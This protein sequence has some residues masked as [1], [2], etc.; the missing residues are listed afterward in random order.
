MRKIKILSWILAAT[1][2]MNACKKSSTET[3]NPT[4]QPVGADP[5]TATLQGNVVDENSQ[6]AIGVTIKVGTKTVT[7]D[8]KGFFRVTGAALDKNASLVT[9]EKT[10]YFKAYRSFCATSGA[11]QVSIKL[12]K[13]NLTGTV[14]ATAGG[15][16]TLSNG[17]KVSLPANGIVV[18]SSNASYTGSVKVFASYI[19]PTAAD[20]AQ[21]IPGSLMA[22]DKNGN[23]VGLTSYGMMAVEL[24]GS[25]GEKLQIKSGSTAQLT[26]VIPTAAQAS[27]PASISLWYVDEQTGLW[28]EEGTATKQ[29]NSYVGT[30]QHFSFWN[31]DVSANFIHL[32]LTLNVPGGQPLANTW[33]K[34]T[35]TQGPYPSSSWGW[36]DSL[37]QVSGLVP[38]NEVLQLEVLSYC[39]DPIYTQNIGPFSQNSILPAITVT[40]TPNSVSTVSGTLLN[41][42]NTAVTNGYAIISLGNQVHYA[43]VD[44]SGHFSTTI[45]N[46][47]SSTAPVQIVGI[48]NGTQQQSST[49]SVTWAAPT[50]SAGNIIACG[51]SAT[52]FITYAVDGGISH[53]LSS[54]VPSD[55]LMCYQTQVSGTTQM[56]VAINCSNVSSNYCYFTFNPTAMAPGTYPI[57][58]VGVDNYAGNNTVLSGSTSTVTNYASVVGDFFQGSFTCNFSSLSVTHTVSGTYKVRRNF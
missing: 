46:C 16:A 14:S 44:G 21:T 47:S 40:P 55:S 7:T 6:P 49:T 37:G 56:Q 35:R 36:T 22:N 24:E 11:N 33:V 15:D 3:N 27:A 5:V 29:G 12:L 58:S 17:S 39:F 43:G 50:V 18:A 8:N 19:D 32:Y 38:P 53:T 54:A 34:L 28:K 45:L 9:A 31:C 4:G 2:V 57:V 42:S 20:I 23:R 10:G 30:V 41:C 51:V 26:T 52:Q 13:R 25:A 1:L 48:D